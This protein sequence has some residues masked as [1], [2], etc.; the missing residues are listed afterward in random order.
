MM[1]GIGKGHSSTL[2]VITLFTHLFSAI[3]I[4]ITTL[5]VTGSF[6]TR[7]AILGKESD[8][9]DFPESASSGVKGGGR[10]KG[11]PPI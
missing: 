9:G 6:P 11:V 1:A 7:D 3:I 5:F 2:G 8:P 4:R 10:S